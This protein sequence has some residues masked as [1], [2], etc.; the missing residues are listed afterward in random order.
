MQV[1]ASPTTIR[2]AVVR[3]RLL[4]KST[5]SQAWA[6]TSSDCFGRRLMKAS[7]ST[8][9]AAVLAAAAAATSSAGISGSGAELLVV[10]PVEAINAV[11]RTAVVLGQRVQTE[12]LDR[13]VVGDTVAVFGVERS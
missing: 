1:S 7:I 6:T 10:G 11:D 12:M 9:V 13:L 5:S 4:R 8:V 2:R 3:N